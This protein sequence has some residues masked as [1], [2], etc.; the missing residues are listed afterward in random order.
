MILQEHDLDLYEL[1]AEADREDAAGIRGTCVGPDAGVP[2]ASLHA[3][4]RAAAELRRWLEQSQ[5][6]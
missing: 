5:L 4:K 1:I 6:R 2:R 3:L